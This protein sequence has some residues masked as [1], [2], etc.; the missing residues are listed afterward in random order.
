M[1]LSDSVR[2][3]LLS[4]THPIPPTALTNAVGHLLQQLNLNVPGTCRD[5]HLFESRC[6][7]E[8]SRK[9]SPERVASCSAPH[10]PHPMPLGT[11]EPPSH[12]TF[13]NMKTPLDGNWGWD[14]YKEVRGH[15]RCCGF[16]YPLRVPPTC[17]DVR[18]C[19]LCLFPILG[20]LFCFLF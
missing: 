14:L 9:E 17:T 4:G 7:P 20:L 6:H 11:L 13:Q 18:M 1:S 2:S 8:A 5:L 10:P 19:K 16:K 3:H 12:R 15:M